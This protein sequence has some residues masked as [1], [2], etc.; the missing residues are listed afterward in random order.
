MKI[1][2]VTIRKE[3]ELRRIKLE[4][5]RLLF[6]SYIIVYLKKLRKPNN[7]LIQMILKSK[8]I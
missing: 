8:L 1:A 7:M 4:I 5:M 6:G 2:I 3:A